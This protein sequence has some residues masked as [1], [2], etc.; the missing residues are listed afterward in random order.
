MTTQE[1]H[2]DDRMRAMPFYIVCDRS[3]SMLGAPLEGVNRLVSEICA[4]LNS[5]PASSDCAHIS[6]I[7]FDTEATIAIPLSSVS[8]LLE[9][10]RYP[11]LTPGGG[12]SFS[13]P[14]DLLIQQIPKDVEALKARNFQV[15]RPAVYFLTDGHDNGGG[16]EPRLEALTRYDSETKTGMRYYPQIV[17]FG[18]GSALEAN[19]D[20]LVWP[21]VRTETYQPRYYLASGSDMAAIMNAI[22]AGLSWSIMTSARAASGGQWVNPAPEPSALGQGSTLQAHDASPFPEGA[23]L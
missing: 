3:G 17:P 5:D 10:E 22:I 1:V 2:Q 8:D 7:A 19:L 16:W 6:L 23:T 12:T 15:F 21:K 18:F 9:A 13:A 14:L 20:A 4:Q 11:T